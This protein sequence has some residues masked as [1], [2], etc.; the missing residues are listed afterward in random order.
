[1]DRDA[2]DA[3]VDDLLQGRHAHLGDVE[4]AV[5]EPPAGGVGGVGLPAVD[6]VRRG[7]GL[8]VVEGGGEGP[9]GGHDQPV[10]EQLARAHAL[11]DALAG[12]VHD[13]DVQLAGTG[14]RSGHR[15]E[16]RHRGLALGVERLHEAVDAKADP[17]VGR[18]ALG[19]R[20]PGAE[21]VRVQR[22]GQVVLEEVGLGVDDRQA[23]VVDQHR[24]GR[25]L[26]DAGLLGDVER[27]ARRRPPVG[28]L[29][30]GAGVE[31][32]QDGG[33]AHRGSQ[34]VTPR[35]AQPP[36]VVG[37]IG[38]GPAAG[39]ADDGR[40]R[41]RAVLVARRRVEEDREPTV[42]VAPPTAAHLGPTSD[43]DRGRVGP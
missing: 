35:H 19:L 29:L 31:G 17:G 4:V 28:R 38:P 3:Q 30:L 26:V 36:G 11:A 15:R 10:D 27:A 33:G 9:A 40:Q 43:R 2:G 7:D 14:G 25:L 39:L 41:Q 37:G 16:H 18:P 34:E 6:L 1:M 5:V 12:P 42:L 24:R 13:L 22:L 21:E 23:G 20:E 32:E 8:E